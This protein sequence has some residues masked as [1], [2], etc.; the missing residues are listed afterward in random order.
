M[1]DSGVVWIGDIP[2]EW[3][4]IRAKWLFSQRI[5]KGNDSLILLAATQK[6]GMIPQSEL[7]GVVKVAEGTDL[8]EFKT[9]QVNDFV[10]SLRSFQGGFELSKYAGVCS[11]AYQVFYAKSKCGFVY[12]K[13][14]FKSLGFIQM[15]NSLT[16]GIRE[17]KNIQYSNF[18]N[19]LLP[20]PPVSI[21]TQIGIFL[22]IKC[23]EIDK[24]VEKTRES[25]EEYKKL[26]QAVIT[27]AVTKGVRGPRPMKPSGV[28]WI[29]DIPEEWEL[30]RLKDIV[31]FEKGKNAA[32]Y[33]KEYVGTHAG[34]YPVYSGQTENGGVM[35]MI[36]SF[37]YD[38]EECL[39]TTT[40]GA[41]T[42]TPRILKGKFSLSQ[43]CL[44]MKK[45]RECC[46][47]YLFYLLHV[48]FAYQ[49]ALIPTYM[50]PSL[51]IEDLRKYIL[52]SPNLPE[53]QEITG[54]LDAKCGEIDRLISKKEQLITEL[55]AY[56]KSLIYEY[57][58]GKKEVP[59]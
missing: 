18:A 53:Q 47:P 36:D 40:V 17:G 39:F 35:G 26:K 23:A 14:L 45:Q 32:M 10:I 7:E 30:S 56:K 37:D 42:M 49:K 21:Q 59:A 41:K 5:S 19:E 9:V 20:I 29:G 24:V 2:K 54:Y 16:V 1:K 8:R 22:D 38:V 52:L 58:T 34:M 15:I 50:Q 25:I 12:Y 48:E 3:R 28:E 46:L 33:T 44:I 51:R 43:N 31:S 6:K 13:Y 11:P 57:V 27:E 55:E 4:V